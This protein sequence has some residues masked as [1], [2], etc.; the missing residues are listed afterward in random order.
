MEEFGGI[1]ATLTT[2]I[3]AL[4]ATLAKLTTQLNNN[5]NNNHNNNIIRNKQNKVKVRKTT[6]RGG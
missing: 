6:R 1:N 5:A 2:T 4:T 3:N